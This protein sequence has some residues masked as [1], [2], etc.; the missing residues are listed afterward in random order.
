MGINYSTAKTIFHIHRKKFKKEFTINNAVDKQAGFRSLKTNDRQLEICVTQGGR[1]LHKT[2]KNQ[3]NV[4]GINELL[5][6]F[7]FLIET[8]KQ[9]QSKN[10]LLTEGL[11]K[12]WYFKFF[13]S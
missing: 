12:I 9:E 13:N 3:K 4:V 11:K 8:V 1:T 5:N 6:A 7:N 2:L 10:E